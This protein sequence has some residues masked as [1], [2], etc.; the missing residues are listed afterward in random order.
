MIPK[1][2]DGRI[3]PRS[4]LA[5]KHGIHVLAG[6]IDSDYHLNLLIQFI[7]HQYKDYN[8]SIGVDRKMILQKKPIYCF[9]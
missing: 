1:K 3:A 7:L 2:H 5:A 4:G 8:V 9:N 6:V